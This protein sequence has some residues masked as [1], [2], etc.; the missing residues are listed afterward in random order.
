[1]GESNP[2]LRVCQGSDL[3]S[4]YNIVYYCVTNTGLQKMLSVKL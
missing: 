1:M 2:G 4:V 3:S